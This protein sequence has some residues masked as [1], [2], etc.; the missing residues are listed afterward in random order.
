MPVWVTLTKLCL[1]DQCLADWVQALYV[2]YICDHA[3]EYNT[4][5]ELTSDNVFVQSIEEIKISLRLRIFVL[6][7]LLILYQF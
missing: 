7:A 6:N 5:K 2:C 1:L 4:L 3:H